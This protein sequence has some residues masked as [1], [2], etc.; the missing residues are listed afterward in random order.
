MGT[1][2]SIKC[3]EITKSIWDWAIT[4][5]TWLTASYIPGVFNTEA[6]Y[7]SHKNDTGMDFFFISIDNKLHYTIQNLHYKDDT[8]GSKDRDYPRAITYKK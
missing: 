7:Q 8:L 5:N 2:N 4:H 3:N 1:L 6:D